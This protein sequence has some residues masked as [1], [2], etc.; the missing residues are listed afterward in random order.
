MD[1]DRLKTYKKLKEGGLTPEEDEKFLSELYDE[2]SHDVPPTSWDAE[3][4]AIEGLSAALHDIYAN[5]DLSALQAMAPVHG[6]YN[7]SLRSIDELLE[8]DKQRE[9]DGF[10]RKINV[11]R[12]LKP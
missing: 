1:P 7:A 4:A 5:N 8:R 2:G 3:K 6:T 9:K 11:G 10:P 12:L